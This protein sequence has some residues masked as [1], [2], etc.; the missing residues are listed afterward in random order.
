MKATI[1]Q[2]QQEDAAAAAGKREAAQALL[3]QVAAANAAML[4]RKAEARIQDAAADAA[5]VA[6]VKD[7][8]ARE[9]VTVSA[10]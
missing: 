10:S 8:A 9:E 4:E 5:I 7:K 1:R 2:H 6:Y 3:H